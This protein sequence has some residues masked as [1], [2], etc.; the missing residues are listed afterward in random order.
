MGRGQ[1]VNKGY[2]CNGKMKGGCPQNLVG[3]DGNIDHGEGSSAS[4]I[5]QDTRIK[6]SNSTIFE[7]VPIVTTGWKGR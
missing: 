2:N 6:K 4:N 7:G 5:L 3:I 1:R